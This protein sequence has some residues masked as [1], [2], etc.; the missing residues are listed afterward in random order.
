ML[1]PQ[2]LKSSEHAE[3]SPG[4]RLAGEKC[5]LGALGQRPCESGD[6]PSEAEAE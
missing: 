4:H 2:P 6:E 3:Q 1:E 5:P